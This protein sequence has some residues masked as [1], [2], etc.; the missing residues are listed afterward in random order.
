MSSVTDD[1]ALEALLEAGLDD[2]VSLDE[3]IWEVAQGDLSAESRAQV[4]RMF[5][6]VYSEDLMVPGD[7]GETGFE[8][9]P[10]SPTEWRERSLVELERFD[11][12][13]QGAGFW[14]R[15]TEHGERA[16]TA[17]SG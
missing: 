10:G 6:R 4:L 13:P 2:W 5:D 11:W 17:D 8:D 9:W 7:L 16:A 1:P 15:L 12:N 3:V 14:L